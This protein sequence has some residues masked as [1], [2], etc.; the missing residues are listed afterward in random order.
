[1]YLSILK[2]VFRSFEIDDCE[3]FRICNKYNSQNL[4]QKLIEIGEAERSEAWQRLC[5]EQELVF[6]HVEL[7]QTMVADVYEAYSASKDSFESSGRINEALSIFLLSEGYTS[8]TLDANVKAILAKEKYMRGEGTIKEYKNAVE[9]FVK[10]YIASFIAIVSMGMWAFPVLI[11]AGLVSG[12]KQRE[13]EKEKDRT[14]RNFI[15]LQRLREYSSA[16]VSSKKMSDDPFSEKLIDNA[17]R[18]KEKTSIV[19]AIKE[20]KDYEAYRSWIKEMIFSVHG[21]SEAGKK[22]T[23]RLEEFSK[24]TKAYQNKI[25][26]SF[27]YGLQKEYQT[28]R[29]E[30]IALYNSTVTFSSRP[31]GVLYCDKG[32]Y[33]K[34]KP[35]DISKYVQYEDV[36]KYYSKNLGFTDVFKLITDKKVYLGPGYYDTTVEIL[37]EIVEKNKNIEQFFSFI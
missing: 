14:F 33:F 35:T 25:L 37:K 16:I 6:S 7:A 2:S 26:H 22:Y 5:A 9:S 4:W 36:V 24:Q 27:Y 31:S 19:G 23:V 8:I 10:S 17:S 34:L 28:D 11:G 1:M 21:K 12:K 20:A 3:L 29:D 13:E 32:I 18:L 15:A 30:V